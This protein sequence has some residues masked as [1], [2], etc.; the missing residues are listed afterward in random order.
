MEYHTERNWNLV[1]DENFMDN[2]NSQSYVVEYQM[3]S[4]R[5]T[6]GERENNP[7]KSV[8]TEYYIWGGLSFVAQLGGILATTIEFSF[9]GAGT[10]IT[11]KIS[12]MV[13]NTCT[14]LCYALSTLI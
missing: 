7:H 9:Y 10:W 14:N 6:N 5:S 4:P 3:V 12:V 1:H 8:K 11:S 2:D 13:G